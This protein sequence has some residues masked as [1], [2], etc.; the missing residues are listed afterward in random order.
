MFD[1]LGAGGQ[2]RH[3]PV[4]NRMIQP[5]GPRSAYFV[6]EQVGQGGGRLADPC[7]QGGFIEA[8]GSG[9]ARQCGRPMRSSLYSPPM[10]IAMRIFK[11]SMPRARRYCQ[12]A[13]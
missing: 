10:L 6:R 9:K 1:F 13:S 4:E 3:H 11:G 8:A 7:D 12:S 2:H 5:N